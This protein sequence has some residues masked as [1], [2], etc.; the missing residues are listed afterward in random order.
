MK[1]NIYMEAYDSPT[2]YFP[3]AVFSFDYQTALD[4]ALKL[5]ALDQMD[6]V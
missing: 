5:A 6:F 3:A 4:L 1:F 2:M